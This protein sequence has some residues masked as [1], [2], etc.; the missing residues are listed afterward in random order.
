V[1]T[2]LRKCEFNTATSWWPWRLIKVEYLNY[3]IELDYCVSYNL[4]NYIYRQL[5][6]R[7]HVVRKAWSPFFICAN[8]HGNIVVKNETMA[9]DQSGIS[10]LHHL[11]RLFCFI[12]PIFYFIYWELMP[13]GHVVRKGWSPVYICANIHIFFEITVITMNLADATDVCSL[14]LTDFSN[15]LIEPEGPQ[16]QQVAFRQLLQFW[17]SGYST[18]FSSYRH[19][20][21]RSLR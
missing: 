11:I 5:M 19:L 8:S 21:D 16:G 18:P 1:P 3:I 9:V 15:T 20:Q 6:P 4:F 13:R 7:G 10:Q 2:Y 17:H 12:Q 14:Q